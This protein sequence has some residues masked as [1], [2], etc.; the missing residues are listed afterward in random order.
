MVLKFSFNFLLMLVLLK[1]KLNSL[2]C[3]GKKIAWDTVTLI[4]WTFEGKFIF[5]PA[6]ISSQI[7]LGVLLATRALLL[8]GRRLSFECCELVIVI[9]NQRSHPFSAVMVVVFR[10]LLFQLWRVHWD[11]TSYYLSSV[12][13]RFNDVFLQDR[14]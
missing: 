1:Y 8:E 2:N 6:G 5:N 3:Y 7:N 14:S 4:H 11:V 10:N 13:L 12:G 9:Q